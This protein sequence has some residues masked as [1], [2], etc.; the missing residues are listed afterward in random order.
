MSS[1][2]FSCEW[3]SAGQDIAP[4]RETVG[5]LT[6]RVGGVSLTKN[7][8]LWSKT[9]RDSVLVSAYPLAMWLAASWWRLSYEPLP[10]L[11]TPPVLD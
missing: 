10:T 1:L 11:R 3:L 5:Q 2:S 8:D 6:I 7:E 9:V 4:L